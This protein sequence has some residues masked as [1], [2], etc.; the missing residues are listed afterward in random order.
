MSWINI[1]DETSLP[2][3]SGVAAWVGGNAVAIFNLGKDGL[4]ALDNIDPASGVSLL[5]RGL[6]CEME[7]E[8][9]VASPLYKQHYNLVTGVC[10]EDTNLV[11]SPFE[12]K[13]EQGKVFVLAKVLGV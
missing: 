1:C 9:C 5:A 8:L 3:G 7:G 12:V 6:I 11:A 2:Q 13:T 10:I 4:F